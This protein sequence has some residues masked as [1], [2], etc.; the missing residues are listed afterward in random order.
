[1]CVELTPEGEQARFRARGD[2]TTARVVDVHEP[3]A[4]DSVGPDFD[5]VEGLALE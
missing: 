3:V 5:T 4:R 2:H 1:V